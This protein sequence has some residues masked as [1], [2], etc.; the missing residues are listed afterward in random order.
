[1]RLTTIW[2]LPAAT[3][4]EKIARTGDWAAQTLAQRLPARVRYWATMQSI[5]RATSG[6]RGQVMATPLAE[7]LSSL[8]GGPDA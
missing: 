3:L 7:V 5:A 1:M 6:R 2:T 4:R 8:D